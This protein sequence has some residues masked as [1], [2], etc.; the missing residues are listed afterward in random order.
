MSIQEDIEGTP[1]LLCFAGSEGPTSL[2]GLG[3]QRLRC[4]RLRDPRGLFRRGPAGKPSSADL[5]HERR[6]PEQVHDQ[7]GAQEEVP[8][9]LAWSFG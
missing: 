3:P 2:E 4:V 5:D 8:R 7:D 1:F 6:R 9:L